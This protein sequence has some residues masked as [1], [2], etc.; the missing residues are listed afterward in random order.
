MAK[1]SARVAAEVSAWMAAK[2]ATGLAEAAATVDGVKRLHYNELLD[3]FKKC[4]VVLLSTHLNLA[5][6][7]CWT[8]D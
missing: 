7:T 3:I 2:V 8:G 5:V 4:A 6:D 1:V